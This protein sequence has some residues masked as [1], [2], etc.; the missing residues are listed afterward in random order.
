[1]NA[2]YQSMRQGLIDVIKESQI[3]IGFSPNPVKLYYPPA[4]LA[5]ALGTG[6]DGIPEAFAAFNAQADALGDMQCTL[7]KNGMYCITVPAEGAQ[8]VRDH[9]P[10]PPFL[11][12]L[13]GLLGQH[14][15]DLTMEDV[16]AVFHKY[17]E[18]VECREIQ[19]DEFDMLVYFTDGQPDAYRYCF[20][21]EMG[22][23][24]YHRFTAADYEALHIEDQ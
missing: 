2:T 8:Y 4:S 5:A 23:I 24:T 21:L 20:A 14:R 9:V 18:H 22:H 7:E 13:I 3:K 16:L 15:H 12:E 6:A 19:S 11:A 17:A 1:M 10:D